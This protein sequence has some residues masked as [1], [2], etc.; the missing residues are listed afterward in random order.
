MTRTDEEI[1]QMINHLIA[2]KKTLPNHSMFGGDNWVVIDAQIDVLHG[3]IQDEDDLYDMQNELG[4]DEEGI[5]T[6]LEAFQWLNG[7]VDDLIYNPEDQVIEKDNKLSYCKKPCNDCPFRKNSFAGWLSDYTP[8]ELHDIVMNE[9][10]FPCHMTHEESINWD[11]G[12][13]KE[14]PLCA[15]ALMYMKKNYKSPK[16]AKLAEVLKDIKHEDCENILS[17]PE[18]FKHHALKL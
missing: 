11:Q 2:F 12:G 1:N 13:T 15:G 14:Y 8:E 5:S 6:V 7:E 10:K 9:I 17:V 16:D 4:L 3:S 18:F